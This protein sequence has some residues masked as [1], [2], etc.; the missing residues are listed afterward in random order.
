[1]ADSD[2]KLDSFHHIAFIVKSNEATAESWTSKFGIGPWRY[3]D[4]ETIKWGRASL[5][6]LPIELIEPVKKDTYW[7]DF[8]ETRGEGINHLC[9]RVPDVDAAAA[10]LVAAGGEVVA[11]APGH[12]AYVSIGGP[13][14]FVMEFLPE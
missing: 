9:C 12:Y 14:S 8:L 4:G 3:T 1:M 2:L 10:K 13:G 5:G 11:A 6:T 7:S